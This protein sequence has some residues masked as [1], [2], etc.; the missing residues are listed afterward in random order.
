MFRDVW[1]FRY[2]CKFE[3][4]SFKQRS[5]L[6]DLFT[7]PA[8]HWISKPTGRLVLLLRSTTFSDQSEVQFLLWV[9]EYR[10]FNV[11]ISVI[12]NVTF[13]KGTW[14]IAS[15]NT[16]CCSCERTW[17]QIIR[18]WKGREMKPGAVCCGVRCVSLHLHKASSSPSTL[19]ECNRLVCSKTRTLKSWA[20]YFGIL[21]TWN[22]EGHWSAGSQDQRHLHQLPGSGHRLNQAVNRKDFPVPTPS[23][24]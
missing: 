18:F 20:P 9:R 7:I 21:R 19:T 6:D 4:S 15:T 16:S 24:S 3:A 8:R 17:K 10:V 1:D 13:L 12:F 2:K 14:F 22:I 23:S 5:A 11:Q